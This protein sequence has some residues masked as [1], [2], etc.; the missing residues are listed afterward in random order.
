MNCC[1]FFLVCYGWGGFA[2]S[3]FSRF[4]S[5]RGQACMGGVFS[6]GIYLGS[7]GVHLWRF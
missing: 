6:V 2:S 7:T 5:S 3:W 4:L 1:Y